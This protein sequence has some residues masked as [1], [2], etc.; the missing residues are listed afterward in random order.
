MSV[1]YWA[2]YGLA[3]AFFWWVEYQ[4]DKW[5]NLFRLTV[6]GE[7]NWWSRDKDGY[8]SR[9]K[10]L[11]N[12]A[13]FFAAATA[14]PVLAQ[15][16]AWPFARIAPLIAA[17]VLAAIAG[18][19]WSV[20]GKNVRVH[21][22]KR[23]EQLAI[24]QRVRMDPDSYR[25]SPFRQADNAGNLI[26]VAGPHFWDVRMPRAMPGPGNIEDPADREKAVEILTAKIKRLAQ[27]PES[28]WFRVGRAGDL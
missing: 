2:M 10:G 17:G 5:S 6:S 19:M 21:R 9:A 18:L 14:F 23:A 16:F 4:D 13:L 27:K 8:Y 28:E 15:V 11:R 7:G 20:I 25:N 3:A 26:W 24:L 22:S 12:T 1:F